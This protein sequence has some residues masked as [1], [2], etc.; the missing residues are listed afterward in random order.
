MRLGLFDLQLFVRSVHDYLCYLTNKGILTVCLT[1]FQLALFQTIPRA[2][3]GKVSAFRISF[4]RIK[5]E[6][7]LGFDG[8]GCATILCF[9]G[10]VEQTLL[11]FTQI[12]LISDKYQSKVVQESIPGS[13]VFFTHRAGFKVCF[14]VAAHEYLAIYWEGF[15]IVYLNFTVRAK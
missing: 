3:L 15:C 7:V 2:F 13:P 11:H 10:E 4:P 5:R 14:L 1:A 9:M 12:S 6:K 8:H